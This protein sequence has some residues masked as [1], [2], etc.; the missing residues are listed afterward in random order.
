M[1][2]KAGIEAEEKTAILYKVVPDSN[3]E[4][5][6][7]YVSLEV[8]GNP[9]EKSHLNTDIKLRTSELMV[10]FYPKLITIA[11]NFADLKFSQENKDAAYEK[12]GEIKQITTATVAE[13][14]EQP[15]KQYLGADIFINSVTVAVPLDPK[16]PDVDCWGL[17][18]G[19]IHF[20]TD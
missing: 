19:S 14:I 8:L 7:E 4:M 20:L 1:F 13:S 12:Y 16:K 10:V 11:T 6:D 17:T 18:L 3:K 2:K 9:L 5:N 15:V